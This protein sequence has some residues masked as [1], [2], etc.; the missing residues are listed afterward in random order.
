M[1]PLEE[2]PLEG[3]APSKFKIICSLLFVGKLNVSCS[4]VEFWVPM[5][6]ATCS[7]PPAGL[8]RLMVICSG[9]LPP[10]PL[11]IGPRLRMISGPV[12][13]AGVGLVAVCKGFTL[14]VP[15]V[16][17]VLR[18]IIISGPLVAAG[19]GLVL[20]SGSS[21]RWPR[22]PALPRDAKACCAPAKSPDCRACPR[23]A[24]F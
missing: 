24:N 23:W 3:A 13:A 12:L 17:A 6:M 19:V 11:L 21:C 22:P 10:L 5:P 1:V 18:L 8:L 14:P 16:P 2:E 15:A 7:P 9:L 20:G 4:A